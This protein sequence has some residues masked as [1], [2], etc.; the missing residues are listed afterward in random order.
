MSEAS[1]VP[2]GGYE[3]LISDKV[4][5]FGNSAHTIAF[6]KRENYARLDLKPELEI[7]SDATKTTVAERVDLSS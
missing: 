1:V 6:L 4:E 2:G 3:I 7:E 5:Y